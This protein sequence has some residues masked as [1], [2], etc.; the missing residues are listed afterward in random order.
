MKSILIITVVSLPI[1]ILLW[2]VKKL[3]NI[4]KYNFKQEQLNKSFEKARR[5]N[6]S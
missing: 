2:I 4:E 6:E 1:I 3:D 5:E